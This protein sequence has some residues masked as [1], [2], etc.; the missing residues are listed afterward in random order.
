MKPNKLTRLSSQ[1]Y[2]EQMSDQHPNNWVFIPLQDQE[3]DD[4]NHLLSDHQSYSWFH[5]NITE[6]WDHEAS[7]YAKILGDVANFEAH[8]SLSLQQDRD[9]CM[10]KLPPRWRDVVLH[11][12]ESSGMKMR[13]VSKTKEANVSSK[14]LTLS[15]VTSKFCRN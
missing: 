4:K 2:L 6:D 1:F 10:Q 9:P 14:G 13:Y 8:T 11:K 7:C 3:T 5:D 12:G 15:L